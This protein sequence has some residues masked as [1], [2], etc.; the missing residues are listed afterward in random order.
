MYCINLYISYIRFMIQ[1]LYA[2]VGGEC[3]VDNPDSP[4]HQ[5]VLI[6]GHLYLSY[7]KEKIS[8]WL[9]SIALQIKTDIR[10]TPA[11]VDFIDSM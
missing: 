5:E 1:K 8:D 10:R 11:A 9:S 3:S 6:G 4:Q 2:L 7:L